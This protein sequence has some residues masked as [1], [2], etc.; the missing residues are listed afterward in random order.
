M[1]LARFIPWTRNWRAHRDMT[2]CNETRDRVQELVDG[3]VL[4]PTERARLVQ[5]LEAC[6]RCGAEADEIRQLKEAIARV[7]SDA[8]AAVVGRL[9]DLARRLCEGAEPGFGL[10]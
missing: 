5:H 1:G 4:H 9:K 8:D 2:L 7:G 10:D 6:V 3:E